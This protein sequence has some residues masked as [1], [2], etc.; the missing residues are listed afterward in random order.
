MSAFR[1][2]CT[3][4]GSPPVLEIAGRYHPENRG[5][6]KTLPRGQR[7]R[8]KRKRLVWSRAREVGNESQRRTHCEQCPLCFGIPLMRCFPISFNS[9]LF[10]K[11]RSHES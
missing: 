2:C 4:L 5:R 8:I 6:F 10:L 1:S 3:G 11:I 9:E 7:L